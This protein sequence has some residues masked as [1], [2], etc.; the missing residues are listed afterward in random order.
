VQGG[1]NNQF[2]EVSPL[3]STM[4]WNAGIQREVLRGTIL[5]LSYVGSRGRNLPVLRN[6]N[7]VPVN[8]LQNVAQT[9]T[10]LA[11]QQVRPNPNVTSFAAFVHEG[12]SWY[13][14]AQV[15]LSRTF[16]ERF[17]FQSTYTFSKAI[18]DGSG[19]FNFSQPNGLDVGDMAGAVDSRINRGLSAFDR[20]HLFAAATRYQTGGS[21]WTRGWQI[22]VVA[23]ARSGVVDTISQTNLHD[24][25]T[26][27]SLP[28]GSALQQRPNVK[29]GA[30]TNV[31]VKATPDGQAI[32]VLMSPSDPNFPFTPSGPFFAT[33]NGTRRL[34]VPFTG[35]GTL[36]KTTVRGPSEFNMDMGLA[37]RFD[38]GSRVGLTIRAEAFNV[39]NHTNLNNPNTSLTVAADANGN[40]IF[41]SPTFGQITTAKSARFMQF[42]A[43]LDF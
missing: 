3:P 37:R 23:L 35:P 15:R 10:A 41:N 9:N 43:R 13:H 32:R 16:S 40:A 21:W 29:A 12:N 34:I 22:N 19:I 42:V 18:D 25:N 1:G 4:V 38:L 26:I 39:L 20:T 8:Q 7:A 5:D 28:G 11:A 33:V 2:G 27:P 17:S 36:G 30:G 6:E 14:S 24:L 31:N